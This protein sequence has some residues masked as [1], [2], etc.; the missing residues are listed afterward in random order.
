M[1]GQAALLQDPASAE[2]QRP[3]AS[4][5][6]PDSRLVDLGE[7]LLSWAGTQSPR[8]PT[9]TAAEPKRRKKGC[10]PARAALTLLGVVAAL[11]H[12]IMM[13]TLT[14]QGQQALDDRPE[15]QPRVH[16]TVVGDDL[17][18]PCTAA[19]T[20]TAADSMHGNCSLPGNGS[21]IATPCCPGRTIGC[22][23][24]GEG[25]GIIMTM[26]AADLASCA[27]KQHSPT[28]LGPGGLPV[29][30]TTTCTVPSRSIEGSFE[31]KISEGVRRGCEPVG[32]VGFVP[33][34]NRSSSLPLL[35]NPLRPFSRP[36]LPFLPI[37]RSA[38]MFNLVPPIRTPLQNN[39]HNN[40]PPPPPPH[41]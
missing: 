25:C 41:P 29:P 14:T 38:Q 13:W 35:K 30:N 33:H 10:G 40:P 15:A 5:A 37:R 32:G 22:G 21:A 18:G 17:K 23:P 36:S 28:C 1:E 16:C 2:P 12:L 27:A 39:N 11:A 19:F 8:T 34:Q 6:P 9:A 7:A 31:W 4:E 24:S 20:C 26:T 3:H